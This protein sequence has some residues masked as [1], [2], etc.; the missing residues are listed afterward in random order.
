MTLDQV[1]AFAEQLLPVERLE[2]WQKCGP[3]R[4]A[5]LPRTDDGF[6][7]CP[8]CWSA[9]DAHGVNMHGPNDARAM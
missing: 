2:R 3:H 5:D 1:L 6:G 7:Y 9:W 4:L 8:H